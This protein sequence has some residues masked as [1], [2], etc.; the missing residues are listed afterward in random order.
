LT[1]SF[2]LI[3][4]KVLASYSI[5]CFQNKLAKGGNIM[6][7]NSIRLLLALLLLCPGIAQADGVTEKDFEVQTTQNL[8]NL[9]TVSPQDPLY[10]QAINFCHGYLVGA[11]HF[12]EAQ[13]AGPNGIRLVCPPD[14]RPSRNSTIGMFIE[15]AKGHPQYMSESPV[16]TEF[17][18]M[19]EKWP[20]K[21]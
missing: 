3:S 15:W 10:S 20:C 18:F 7:R 19:I 9:C 8:I 13:A 2:S 12:H 11:F 14:P 1:T 17:R 16:E 6:G 4:Y 5:T 21:Q